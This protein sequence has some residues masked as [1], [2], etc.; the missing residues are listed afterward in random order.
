MKLLRLQRKFSRNKIVSVAKLISKGFFTRHRDETV[1]T[2]GVTC[3]KNVTK[4][5]LNPLG[6][7]SRTLHACRCTLRH[8]RHARKGTACMD[9]HPLQAML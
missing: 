8:M 6:K 4:A 3:K 5:H 7:D 2:L 9:W 1:R